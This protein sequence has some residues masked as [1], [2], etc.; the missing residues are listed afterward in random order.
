M[1]KQTPP[2]AAY[3]ATRLRRLR[4]K[5]WSR[6]LTQETLLSVND[7][8]WPLFVIDGNGDN[9]PIQSMPGVERRTIKTVLQACEDASNIG[10]PL[11]SLFPYTD[12]T[13]RSDDGIEATNTENLICRTVR[14]I[15][16]EFPDLGVMC[17]VALDPYT[18]HG[19][20]GL[21]DSSGRV[22]ND[23]TVDVLVA[24]S[25]SLA[26]AGCDI[27]APSDMMDGRVGAIRQGLEDKHFHDTLIMSYAVKYAS[28]LYGPFRE[29][30]G[31]GARLVGDKKTYQMN[32]ANTDESIREATLDVAEGADML[33]IKPGLPY[34]DIVSRIKQA[35]SVPTFS[36]QVSG[37]YA[38]IKAAA[39]NQWIEEDSVILESLISFKRAGCDG[40]LTYFAPNAAK[41]LKRH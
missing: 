5:D 27:I 21:L 16:S 38:M 35:C 20:D 3:P 30:V 26:E 15:K 39:Q 37:E 18:S 7:L 10:I 2:Q 11:I 17:D 22:M 14:A 41:L 25:L 19:H 13:L 23:A 12:N 36:Y 9:Q 8:I 28:S 40:V 6:R 24:Q 34:L 32:P 4:Q 33:L 29:A 31:S 1:A